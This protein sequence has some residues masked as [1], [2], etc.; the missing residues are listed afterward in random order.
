MTSTQQSN[1]D[2][3]QLNPEALKVL[4]ELEHRRARVTPRTMN[5]CAEELELMKQV[6]VEAKGTSYSKDSAPYAVIKGEDGTW[7]YTASMNHAPHVASFVKHKA[8]EKIRK[9]QQIDRMREKLE[10]RKRA[11]EEE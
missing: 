7:D 1:M 4:K 5:V 9:H 10:Q 2:I 3:T 11:R 6:L 8:Q